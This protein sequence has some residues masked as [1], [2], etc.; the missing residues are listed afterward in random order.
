VPTSGTT[1]RSAIASL[2]GLG[3]YGLAGAAGAAKALAAPVLISGALYNK[4][5][6]RGLT[7]L[8]TERPRAIRELERPVAGALSRMGGVYQEQPEE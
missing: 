1:E 5:V 6:M 4:P 2:L 8:A 3:G 7:A